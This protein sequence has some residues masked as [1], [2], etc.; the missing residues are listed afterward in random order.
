MARSIDGHHC[1]KLKYALSEESDEAN[2]RYQPK[3]HFWAQFG[4]KMPILRPKHFYSKIRKRHFSRLT[5]D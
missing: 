2:L 4:P 3:T 1:N 5:K